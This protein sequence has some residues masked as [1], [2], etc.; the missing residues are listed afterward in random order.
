LSFLA[1][2][3]SF[4]KQQTNRSVWERSEMKD[5]QLPFFTVEI[6]GKTLAVVEAPEDVTAEA[7]CYRIVDEVS[8]LEPFRGS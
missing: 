7:T 3:D 2:N 1:K 5:Y 4:P 6:A 8:D